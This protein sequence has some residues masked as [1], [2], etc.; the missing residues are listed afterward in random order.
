V[1]I[2]RFTTECPRCVAL[3]AEI[4]ELKRNSKPG[5]LFRPS[6]PKRWKPRITFTETELR[7]M[8]EANENA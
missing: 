1:K 7:R 8:S 6:Q 2:M 5:E 4:A 3:E